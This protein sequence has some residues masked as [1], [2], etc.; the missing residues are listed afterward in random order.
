MKN[1]TDLYEQIKDFADNHP[2]VN[3][4]L[5][6]GSE[7]EIESITFNYRTLILMPFGSNT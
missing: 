1:L 3:E 7:E 5:L 2:M 6:V 4:F